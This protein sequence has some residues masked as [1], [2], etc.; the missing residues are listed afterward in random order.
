VSFLKPPA[1]QN[2]H[3]GNSDPLDEQ[4]FIV[5][6]IN[7]I[8]QSPD[9]SS[10]AIIITYDDSDGWYDHVLG[11][12]VRQSQDTVDELDGPGKCG[13][14]TA[15]PATQ[16]RCGVGPRLPLLVISPWARQNYVDNTFAEQ[17][18]ITQ[19]IEDNWSLGR[20]GQGSADLTAGSLD[21]MFDFN[22]HDQRAPAIIMNDTTGEIEKTIPAPGRGKTS[23]APPK[24]SASNKWAG[25]IRCAVNRH[26]RHAVTV[27]C[28]V[29]KSASKAFRDQRIEVLLHRNGRL[30]ASRTG[31]FGRRIQL[32]GRFGGQY[33][34]AVD[35]AGNVK[36][37]RAFRV[38]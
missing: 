29:S 34:L 6:E 24:R 8:E 9:W 22:P 13:S 16:D 30:A 12:I 31:R 23:T 10:T 11:P 19:F 25:T 3:A 2:A 38:A 17:A 21:G 33:T 15:T 32:H 18:S 1:Y 26:E 14:T 20:I 27:T 35:F 37:M 28:N 36:V 4:K 5:D 7:A